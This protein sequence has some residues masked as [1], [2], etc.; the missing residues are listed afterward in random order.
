MVKQS[1]MERAL[2]LVALSIVVLSSAF[3]GC[4][5]TGS[6]TGAMTY[7]GGDEN[8]V[9]V[10]HGIYFHPEI[11]LPEAEIHCKKFRK[12]PRLLSCQSFWTNSCD[13]VCEEPI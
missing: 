4:S 1:P 7:G 9:T 8:G 10:Y 12:T 6:Y 11:T 13:Y 2:R 5:Q 3:L